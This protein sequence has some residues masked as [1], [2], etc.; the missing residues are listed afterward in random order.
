VGACGVRVQFGLDDDAALLFSFQL[1]VS[2]G[3]LAC[4]AKCM[5]EFSFPVSISHSL[6]TF[7]SRFVCLL[8]V[9]S[10]L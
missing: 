8:R 6:H 2:G 3:R 5:L 9:V 7:H 10:G 4:A 1:V